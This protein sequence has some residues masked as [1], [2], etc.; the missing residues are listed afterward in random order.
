[1][2]V[3]RLGAGRVVYPSRY[4]AARV[5][6]ELETLLGDATIAAAADDVGRQV[7]AESGAAAAATAILAVLAARQG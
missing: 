3:A 5:A 7:R 6:R 2:R 1:V 4:R